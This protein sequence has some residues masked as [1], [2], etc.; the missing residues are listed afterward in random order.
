M[1]PA[2]QQTSNKVPLD[3]FRVIPEKSRKFLFVRKNTLQLT[4]F[5]EI[6]QHQLQGT[7]ISPF[8]SL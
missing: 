8:P 7:Q 4:P 1:S 5:F 2:M 6:L 3:G